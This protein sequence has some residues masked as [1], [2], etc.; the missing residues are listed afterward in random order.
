M[1][2]LIF[3]NPYL[4]PKESVYQAE[5][6]KEEFNKLGVE[7]DVISDGFSR[8]AIS[9]DRAQADLPKPDFAVYLDKDKYLSNVLSK[10]GM[11]LFNRH[12]A[13]RVCDDKGET[14]VALCGR[15]IKFPK[16]VFGGLCYSS[17]LKIKE[18]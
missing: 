6:L 15:G 17:D 8:V 12:Q 1:R 13:V 16:T 10:G 5:R 9:G 2:G 3:I 4:V 14:Y 18:E 11:R 7:I